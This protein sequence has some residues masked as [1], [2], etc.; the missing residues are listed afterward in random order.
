[1]TGVL[2]EGVVP[3]TSRDACKSLSLPPSKMSCFNRDLNVIS[4]LW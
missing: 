2:P 1:M 4:G 3:V